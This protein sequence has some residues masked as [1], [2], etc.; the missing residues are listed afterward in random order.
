MTDFADKSLPDWLVEMRSRAPAST[1]GAADSS[2]ER[3]PEV[4][5][6][7]VVQSMD[8]DTDE[9]QLGL[10]FEINDFEEYASVA[11]VSLDTL[12]ATDNDVAITLSKAGEADAVVEGDIVAPVWWTQLSAV[13]GH[14][15]PDLATAIGRGPKLDG[16]MCLLS[17]AA[18]RSGMRTMLAQA[19]SSLRL[20]CSWRSHA[21]A[22]ATS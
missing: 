1:L 17:S 19:S 18:C 2:R 10:V 15:S 7:Y 5:T 4:G 6:I 3:R 21:T 8:L 11:L 20:G 12:F 14:I 22:S 13:A 9:G 16:L